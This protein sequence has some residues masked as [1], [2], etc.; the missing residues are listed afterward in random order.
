MTL[1][2]AI[3]IVRLRVVEPLSFDLEESQRIPLLLGLSGRTATALALT[4]A[5]VLA[6]GAL[7]T[8]RHKD[9]RLMLATG[10]AIGALVV[11]GW[12]ATG[13]AGFEPLDT[14]RIESFS[15]VAP[16]ADTILYL[17]LSS[18]IKP[19]FPVGAVLGVITGAFLAAL[20]AGH[21]RWE[22]P[23]DARELRR[24]ILGAALMGAGG[25]AALGCTIGQGITGISTLSL[26]SLL[27]IASIF[28][29][30]RLGLYWLVER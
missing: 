13:V 28:A 14:R 4:S 19:D 8:S 26:T 29:G 18:G 3:G 5:M 16:L 10:F 25:V 27:A 21:F 7:M 6:I 23:D 24:H 2:G 15:F 12:W 9:S 20:T 11:L 22:A 17:L 30:A 1:R